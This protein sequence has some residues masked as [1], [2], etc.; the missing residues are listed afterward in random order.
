MVPGARDREARDVVSK[1]QFAG[2]A[3]WVT[4]RPPE[5]LGFV[6]VHYQCQLT[7]PSRLADV[8]LPTGQAVRTET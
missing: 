5:A 6:S 3:R 4:A 8:E 2:L 7:K 1:N